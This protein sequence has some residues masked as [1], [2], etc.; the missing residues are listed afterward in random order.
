[1][2][3]QMKNH[4]YS[5]DY[6]MVMNLAQVMLVGCGLEVFLSERRAQ[7]VKN[8]THKA[9]QRSKQRQSTLLTSKVD[10]EMPLR[11]SASTR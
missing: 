4:G 9:R 8:K 7:D 5:G 2:N 1:L 3:E 6:D 10:G 11:G